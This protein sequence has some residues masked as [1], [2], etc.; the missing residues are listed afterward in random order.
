MGQS[1]ERSWYVSI[2]QPLG[3][4]AKARFGHRKGNAGWVWDEIPFPLMNEINTERLVLDELYGAVC[5]FLERNG[6]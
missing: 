3:G 1:R 5:E 4:E 2:V 6:G